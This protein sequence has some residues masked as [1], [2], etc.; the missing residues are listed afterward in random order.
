MYLI[1]DLDCGR[2]LRVKMLTKVEDSSW[3]F[4]TF[5]ED[6]ARLNKQDLE[7]WASNFG[8]MLIDRQRASGG[9][10]DSHPST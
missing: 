6:F 10:V 7:F 5:V 2:K 9:G 8:G 4:I 3:F 1:I